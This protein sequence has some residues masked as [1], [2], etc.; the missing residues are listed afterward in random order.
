MWAD[1]ADMD[2]MKAFEAMAVMMDMPKETVTLL[3]KK[4]Q[5]VPR[6]DPALLAQL[7]TDLDHK[8]FGVRQKATVDLEKLAGQARA[9]LEKAFVK[10]A[11]AEAHSRLK[12]L[13]DRLDN[14]AA[15]ADEVRV[16]RALEILER[17]G[18]PEARELLQVLAGGAP[19]A[20]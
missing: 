13:L 11:S 7:V 20:R 4:L 6:A 15:S 12:R 10:P 1:L 16:V 18:T 5:P 9:E 2:G 19:E 17:L 8:T 14:Q 3:T